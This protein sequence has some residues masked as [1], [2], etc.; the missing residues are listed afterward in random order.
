MGDLLKAERLETKIS[1]ATSHITQVLLD[2]NLEDPV[3]FKAMEH[4]NYTLEN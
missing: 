4:Q 1:K 2:G 3:V